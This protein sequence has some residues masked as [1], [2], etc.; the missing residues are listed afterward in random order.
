MG[1]N[2]S[3][4]VTAVLFGSAILVLFA[5]ACCYGNGGRLAESKYRHWMRGRQRA[6]MLN[7]KFLV[8]NPRAWP[9]RKLNSTHPAH[10]RVILAHT[11]ATD[12]F[13][14]GLVDATQDYHAA[15]VDSW[16][17]PSAFSLFDD[18][19]LSNVVATPLFYDWP[20]GVYSP[21]AVIMGSSLR[22]GDD[23]TSAISPMASQVLREVEMRYDPSI[24]DEVHLLLADGHVRS[25]RIDDYVTN[26]WVYVSARDN[27]IDL[28]AQ[29]K[30]FRIP[31]ELP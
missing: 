26:E 1:Y 19:K 12:E 24:P 17:C 27:E 25:K 6:M 16:F 3:K 11:L 4:K 30:P 28:I 20:N 5:L 13:P 7:V 2:F 31:M 18:K 21:N 9:L 15:L 8:M 29:E 22:I 23:W 10:W 14:K